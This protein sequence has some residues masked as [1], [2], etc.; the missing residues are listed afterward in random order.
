MQE[1]SAP[2]ERIEAQAYK[3]QELAFCVLTLFLTAALLLL[4][5]EFAKLL[6]EP[7]PAAIL[8]L[9][10]CFL[11]KLIEILWLLQHR[12]GISQKVAHLE[13]A[14]S[15][16][17]LF[18]LSGVLA[19]ITDRDDA[20][21]FVLL[22]IPILQ[23]AYHF[24]LIP[25]LLTVL[26]AIGMIFG[27]AIHFFTV[28]PPPR[29]TE[30]LESGMIS[31]IYLLMGM[32]VW[33]LVNQLRK[34][35]S[36]LYR[37]LSELAAAREKLAREEKLAAVGRLAAG[38]AHEIRNP[39]A[40]ISSSLATAEYPDLA[41]NQRQEMFEIAMW[42]AKRLETLTSDFLS[43]ARPSAPQRVDADIAEIL[44]HVL[45]A[46]HMRAV[47]KLI[48]MEAGP[49]YGLASVDALQL[50]GALVNLCL[51]AIDATPER[52]RITLTT[53]AED[54]QLMIDVSD[55]GPAIAEGD[56]SRIFEP[57]FT[58]KGNGTGLGLA[59]ARGVARAHDGDLWVSSNKEGAVTFT[60][61]LKM[62][63]MSECD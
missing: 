29:R 63:S 57:F 51:N 45:G 23:S 7:S 58:T 20:P 35:E 21:Y 16:T 40:V 36:L 4:H 52:G 50:E 12:D 59:I 32:L 18:A 28:H 48:Q 3:T 31:L 41:L 34:K 13:S 6:G 17:G 30:F 60:L 43:Y 42:E 62:L 39:V 24:K 9:V 33:S 46:T 19:I 25:T 54:G 38:I 55:T 26:A 10:L 61:S 47:K 8:L 1:S 49:A 15:M 37:K 27:W 11:L 53:R 56:L 5:T 44:D 14:I 2:L 22:S